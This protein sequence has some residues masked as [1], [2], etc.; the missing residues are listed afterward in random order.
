MT[1]TR[2]KLAFNSPDSE[3]PPAIHKIRV[4]LL[5]QIPDTNAL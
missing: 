3:D 2:H 1:R 4:Q 5:E